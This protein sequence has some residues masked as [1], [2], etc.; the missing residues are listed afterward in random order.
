VFLDRDGT[1][2]VEVE[3]LDD[4]ARCQLLP[5]VGEAIACLNR[6]GFLVIVVTNQA[7]VG[8]GRFPIEAIG[9]VHARLDE[10]L[11]PVHAHIDGYYFCP[12]H[13]DDRCHCRKPLPGMIHEA[14]AAHSIDLSRSFMI[15]D[16]CSD[17]GAGVAAGCA[18]GLVLTGYGPTQLAECRRSGIR[19]SFVANDLGEAVAHIL[20]EGNF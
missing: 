20:T 4:P 19:P 5:R 17:V 13:P 3:Y 6:K 14:A 11:A 8:R 18:A 16:K 9:P 2:N 7:G 10:L 15:G 12:H 1:I